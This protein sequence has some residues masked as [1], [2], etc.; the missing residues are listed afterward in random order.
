MTKQGPTFELRV[1]GGVG[2]EGWGWASRDGGG[3]VGWGG[4][5]EGWMREEA[6]EGKGG[7]EEGRGVPCKEGDGFY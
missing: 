1:C 7:G 5:R 4:D 2:L 6:G 3:H